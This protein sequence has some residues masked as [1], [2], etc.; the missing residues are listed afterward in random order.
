MNRRN[1]FKALLGTGAAILTAPYVKI[2]KLFAAP[3]AVVPPFTKFTFPII[4]RHYPRCDIVS[5]QPM[6]KPIFYLDY[7][8][9]KRPWWKRS[10]AAMRDCF[11]PG[12]C[13]S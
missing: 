3:Q 2:A 7:L 10:A 12:S 4:R 13:T 9:K 5:V 11:G 6:S 8:Y 1:F